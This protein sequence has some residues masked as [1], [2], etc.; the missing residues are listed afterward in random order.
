MN[1]ILGF[2]DQDTLEIVAEPKI[3]GVSASILYK[4]GELFIG[5]TR[6]NGFEGEDITENIKVVKGVPVKL[7]SNDYPELLEIRGEVYMNH[8]DFIKLNKLQKFRN[9]KKT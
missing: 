2:N 1:K 5:S 4:D 3:D 8:E 9:F 7:K 6:G